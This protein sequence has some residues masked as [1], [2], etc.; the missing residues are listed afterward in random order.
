MDDLDVDPLTD[1]IQPTIASFD[2]SEA[3][4]VYYPTKRVIYVACKSST[5]ENHNDKVLSVY[6]RRNASNQ[7]VEDISIDDASVSDWIVDGSNLYSVSSVDQNVYKWFTRNSSGGVGQNHKY[8]TKAYTYGAPANGKEFNTL[9]LEGFI[10]ERTKM[11]VTV[12]YGILGT[13]GTSEKI[14][15]WDDSTYVSTQKI[16][17]LGTDIVG[18]LGLGA[19]SESIRDSYA[20]SVPIHFDVKKSTRFKIKVETV[21]DD[22]TTPESYWAISN[23][24][25]NVDL[26]EHEGIKQ[27]NSND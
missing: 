24:G 18:E 6:I 15:E 9:Y 12:L 17:A 4:A 5:D 23:P 7:F 20:F 21:Y 19:V 8:V 22:E 27:I 3:A 2:F 14:L 10:G 25:V 1:A 13:E 16:S 26:G 11:K